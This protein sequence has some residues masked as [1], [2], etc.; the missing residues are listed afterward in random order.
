MAEAQ[1]TAT[2]ATLSLL[3]R[4]IKQA[5]ATDAA[6]SA[7]IQEIKRDLNLP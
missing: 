6:S 2:S 1:P 4:S 7:T 3:A 5:E